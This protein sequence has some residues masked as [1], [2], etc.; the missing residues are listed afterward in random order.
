MDIEKLAVPDLVYW[1]KHFICEVHK[2]DGSFYPTESLMSLFTGLQRHIRIEGGRPSVNF[3][4]QPEY[5]ELK[6]VLDAQLKHLKKKG[7]DTARKAAQVISEE[8]EN[9]L[10][11]KKLLGDHSPQ[12]LLDT[13][14]FNNG[15]YFA[16]RS[17]MEHRQLRHDPPQITVDD[18]AHLVIS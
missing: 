16:L 10:W 6:L 8:Q 17:G 1:M 4:S 13:M 14:V 15:L 18:I 12:A 2:Q 5:A 11:E 7:V 3:F 9:L